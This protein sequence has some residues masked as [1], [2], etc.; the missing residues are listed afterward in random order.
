MKVGIA[1][2]ERE[3]AAQLEAEIVR[4]GY[5]TVTCADVFGA[6]SAKPDLVLCE[7]AEGSRL[8]GLYQGLQLAASSPEPV[9]VVV[10]LPA[11]AVT[12]VGRA[13]SAGAVD[14]LFQPIDPREIK[15]EIDFLLASP[16]P[17]TPGKA[18][19]LRKLRATRLVGECPN[20]L[21]CLDEAMRASRCEANVLLVG[22]TGTGKEMF[23]QAIHELSHRSG[24]PYVAVNCAGLAETLLESELFGH[25]KGAFTGATVDRPG[26]FEVVGA[27]TLLLDE[28]GDI[29]PALQMK[30][31]RVIEQR[32]FQRVGQNKSLPFHGRLVSAT[33]VDLDKA[34]EDSRF[35]RDL[36]GRINQFRIRVPPLRERRSDIR[37]L[38][39]RFLRSHGR[40]RSVDIS[41]SAMDILLAYDFPGNVRQLENAIRSALAQSDP[42]PLI[43]P[44]HW[45]QEILQAA[46][47]T[48]ASEALVIRVPQPLSYKDALTEATRE[49]DRVYLGALLRKHAGNQSQAATEAGIDRKTFAARVKA[50]LPGCDG[51]PDEQRRNGA[52]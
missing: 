48:H 25:A 52:D 41:H 5:E 46:K 43:L 11:G 2:V 14:V 15:A 40:G 23:S 24:N 7:W 34:V 10:I 22:E 37:P 26:R 8:A 51:G 28:I 12:A 9:P 19:C 45:P 39:F 27:G 49:V 42:G 38:V 47:P 32:E 29:K 18:E 4:C 13:R 30:L 44:Q 50:A 21:K 17:M 16:Q 20:F 35:R 1:T 3:L 31:L 33:S 36:L 6:L